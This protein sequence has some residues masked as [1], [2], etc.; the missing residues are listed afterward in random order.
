MLTQKDIT[1]VVVTHDS[2]QVLP[3]CLMALIGQGVDVIVVDNASTDASAD[4]AVALGASLLRNPRNEGYGRA[5]NRGVLAAQTPLVLIVNPDLVLQDGAVEALLAAADRWPDAGL[6]APR[7]TEPSGRVFF[8]PRSLLSPAFLN[9]RGEGTLPQGDVCAP[10]LSGACLLVRREVFVR[11]G[12][13]D[14][15]I[16][17]FYEDDDLCRRMR[18]A[19]QALVHVDAAHAGHGRGRSSSPKPG[20]RFTARWHMAWSRAYIADK[21]GLPTGAIWSFVENAI[22][23]VLCLLTLNRNLI[24]RSAG[25]AAGSL[26]WLRGRTAL[27]RQ[28]LDPAPSD[29]PASE[30]RQAR[31]RIT[32][33]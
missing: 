17:L 8:Q 28:E 27:D 25:S 18:D 12:G 23:T 3:D 31:S 14:P 2:A 22:K 13:F 24:E 10:F 21:Y 4:V 16:F 9:Q 15:Q 5:N 6:F 32:S 29:R 20:R 11:L 30:D 19:G 26:A 7:I 33:R 1:A